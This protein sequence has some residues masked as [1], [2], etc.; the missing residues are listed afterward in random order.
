MV[1]RALAPQ[2]WGAPGSLGMALLTLG[3]VHDAHTEARDD[4]SQEPVLERVA[5]QPVQEG[6]ESEEQGLGGGD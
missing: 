4:V 1:G 5:G 2:L 3:Q 6:Q